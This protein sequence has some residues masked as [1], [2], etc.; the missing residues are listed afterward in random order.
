M[1]KRVSQWFYR[2]STGW[3]ALAGLVIFILFSATVLPAQS[4]KMDADSAQAGTPDLSLFYT[5]AD[6]YRMAEAYGEEGRQAFIHARLTFDVVWPVVY[7]FFLSTSISWLLKTSISPDSR[8]LSLNIV[9]MLAFLL[10]FLEN[11]SNILIMARYPDPTP[12]IDWLAPIF[13]LSKWAMVGGSMMILLYAIY[14]KIRSLVRSNSH[15]A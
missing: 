7:L 1:V 14:L 5:P 2:L 12:I 13:T 4:A 3:V 6:L 9:P 8:L 11:F 10:D 15:V